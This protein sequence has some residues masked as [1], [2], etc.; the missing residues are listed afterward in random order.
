[1]EHYEEFN[2]FEVGYLVDGIVASGVKTLTNAG[3]SVKT[4][5][6]GCGFSIRG[7]FEESDDKFVIEIKRDGRT[8]GFS[9]QIPVIARL[10]GECMMKLVGPYMRANEGK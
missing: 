8:A 1:M 4:E 7:E 6:D 5:W 9:G 3:W 2:G 10:F